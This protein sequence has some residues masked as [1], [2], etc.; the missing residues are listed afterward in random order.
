MRKKYLVSYDIAD[1][2]RLSQIYK[3]MRG[4]GN[5]LQYSVFLC[6]LSIKERVIMISELSHIINHSQDSVYI[7]ELGNSNSRI[8]EKVISLGTVKKFEDRAAIII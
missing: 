3:K 6:D 1:P 7:F 8:E 5:G 2:K 4:Y